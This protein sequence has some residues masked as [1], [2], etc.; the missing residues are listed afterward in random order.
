MTL[1]IV[2]IIRT[3]DTVWPVY[4]GG[5]WGVPDINF[6]GAYMWPTCGR[7]DT[8]GPHDGPM[9]IAIWVYFVV[10]S[11]LVTEVLHAISDYAASYNNDI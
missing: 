5:Q 9:I 10:I 2:S 3:R 8:G 1:P 4:V 6:H 11:E 7:Q